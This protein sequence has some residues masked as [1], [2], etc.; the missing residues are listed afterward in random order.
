MQWALWLGFLPKQ[1]GFCG[2]LWVRTKDEHDF[3]E[4]GWKGFQGDLCGLS[5]LTIHFQRHGLAENTLLSFVFSSS[6]LRLIKKMWMISC[7]LWKLPSLRVVEH[8][9]YAN[10]HIF[11]FSKGLLQS[12][13][14]SQKSGMYFV[15]FILSSQSFERYHLVFNSSLLRF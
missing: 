12:G 5:T 15:S 3:R 8:I 7:S 11:K 6:V 9:H 13:E 4:N 1:E 2:M 14:D 10:E